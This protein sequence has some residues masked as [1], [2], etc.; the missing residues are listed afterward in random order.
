MEA[1]ATLFSRRRREGSSECDYLYAEV[2]PKA[3]TW[4]R[5]WSL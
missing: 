5:P 1:A 3:M 2:D 4:L